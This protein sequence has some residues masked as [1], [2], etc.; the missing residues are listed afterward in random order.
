MNSTGPL[1]RPVR[2]KEEN[3]H[4]SIEN[5][6]ATIGA[7]YPTEIEKPVAV[8]DVA[9]SSGP[10][11][12]GAGGPVVAGMPFLAVTDIT[13]ADP[14]GTEAGGPVGTGTRFRAVTDVAEASGPA[15]TS[16]GGP[17]IAGTGFRAVTDVAGASGP[18]GTG[19][20]G[21]VVT[22]TQF[23]AVAEV[24]APFEET[25]GDLQGDSGEVDQ[26]SKIHVEDT[27]SHPGVIGRT[28]VSD[29]V[30]KRNIPGSLEIYTDPA[31][32]RKTSEEEP[33]EYSTHSGSLDQRSESSN[34][35]GTEDTEDG[36]AIMVGVVGSAAPWFLTGWAN[37]VEVEFMIDTGCQVT[38]LATS[39][40]EKMCKVHPQVKSRIRLCT[41]RLVSADSSPL[42]VVGQINLDVVF[43]R[44]QCNMCCVVASIGSDGLLG[45]EALQS[46]L[47]VVPITRI[48]NCSG[49]SSIC[50][51]ASYGQKA[52]R[53]CNYTT[54][55]HP[56]RQGIVVNG[57]G[58][59]L[60]DRYVVD[61]ADWHRP[62]SKRNRN[63]LRIC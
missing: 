6:I 51:Q 48:W 62:V 41:R 20:G 35:D 2:K 58:F 15:V 29:G 17:V 1:L 27:G 24:H 36:D 47:I 52:G 45:T 9:G 43:P 32:I 59:F 57:S 44:L 23:L 12:T 33:I 26:N 61:H 63:V 42:T 8:A 22:G 49:T 25:E 28:E 4:D 21:P 38:I 16:A 39:V 55:T 54:E 14:T 46:C 7:A 56:R 18:A 10:A 60:V 5:D 19:A 40:F 34:T 30:R 11:V 37:D 53:R 50:E 13:E 3:S 31:P